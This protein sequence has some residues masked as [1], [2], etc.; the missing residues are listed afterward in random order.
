MKLRDTFIT[1]EP[2][3]S[4]EPRPALGVL[5]E[6]LQGIGDRSL[7]AAQ[8]YL[9]GT[10][11]AVR[12]DWVPAV[13]DNVEF[14]V[15]AVRRVGRVHDVAG[16]E[17][18][19]QVGEGEYNI[20]PVEKLSPFST[21]SRR[22]VAR[23]Q[24]RAALTDSSPMFHETRALIP[25][26]GTDYSMTLEFQ[27]GRRPTMDAVLTY[28]AR[29]YP[30]ARVIDGDDSHPTKLGVVLAFAD[31]AAERQA[32][33]VSGGVGS[34]VS[35]QLSGPKN[36]P[37]D[38]DNA[39]GI[40]K[41]EIEGT[42]K[43]GEDEVAKCALLEAS[44]ACLV[45]IAEANPSYD[46]IETS[47]EETA[48]GVVSHYEVRQAGARCFVKEGRL[49]TV[50]SEGASP[51]VGTIEA[52]DTGVIAYLAH[53]RIEAS[54]YDAGQGPLSI[55][56]N[57]PGANDTGSYVVKADALVEGV[58]SEVDYRREEERWRKDQEQAREEE[59]RR[60][61]RQ[62]RPTVDEQVV[63]APKVKRRREPEQEFE[64]SGVVEVGLQSEEDGEVR[65]TIGGPGLHMAVDESAEKYWA[66]YYGDYGEKLTD[67]VSRHEGR[68][69][70][71]VA[72]THA[73]WREAGQGVPSEADVRLLVRLFTAQVDPSGMPPEGGD[74]PPE[75]GDAPSAPSAPGWFDTFRQ[76][77]R[78]KKDDAERARQEQERLK[79]EDRQWKQDQAHEWSS[80]QTP[81]AL[82]K[83]LLE[84]AGI[85]DK[86]HAYAVKLVAKYVAKLP[87]K[88][89]AQIKV[90]D[91]N[92]MQTLLP[93]AIGL[94]S[95]DERALLAKRY[96]GVQTP[97]H[98]GKGWFRDPARNQP[99]LQR[100]LDVQRKLQPQQP[101]QPQPQQPQPQGQGQGQGQPQGPSQGQP[102]PQGQ[103][104]PQQGQEV[105]L[106]PGQVLVDPA[107]G[108][109][110]QLSGPTR[111]KVA[112]VKPP[113]VLTG[114][115]F[116][117]ESEMTPE[118]PGKRAP[119]PALEKGD[120]FKVGRFGPTWEVVKP[121]GVTGFVQR[122]GHKRK[123]F[124][125]THSRDTGEI[126]VYP[127]NQG[128]GDRTGEPVAYGPLNLVEQA[129]R[130]AREDV[131]AYS[132]RRPPALS[133]LRFR[134][135]DLK[136]VGDYLVLTVVW[137]PEA[138]SAMASASV[139]HNL[140]SFVKQ[141][142]SE[143]ERIDLGFIGRP[144]VD[145]VDFDLGI[146][147]VRVRSS[148]A[149]VAPSVI[150]ER[151]DERYHELA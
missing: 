91:P 52:S 77:R 27:A 80:Q 4:P 111:V 110:Y 104:Q 90:D 137:D 86:V 61:R 125:Y 9:F 145:M 144:V 150:I 105:E 121:E 64:F 97:E 102:S 132:G 129:K 141:R 140:K 83:A 15:G 113:E 107:T 42:G 71:I 12:Q 146:A 75:G 66:D 130:A 48:R 120:R 117:D 13:G 7:R 14:A 28:V 38:R 30:G 65:E 67:P 33:A 78:Q 138:T 3:K 68:V 142:A 16:K 87:P 5:K 44:G 100:G 82:A 24:V 62:H 57:E 88:Q 49:T 40:G 60:R 59:N 122:D 29:R 8:D 127:V 114:F 58:M 39:V 43:I 56:E 147:E 63:E 17:A 1:A 115:D 139:V 96:T 118:E 89:R 31:N 53:E 35:A 2:K 36:P 85:D 51:A 23:D 131:E 34:M 81:D 70:R 103:G 106:T 20:V 10:D 69:R 22:A 74:M 116:F 143:K 128:S 136:R 98:L 41:E 76:K 124:G 94:L 73:G 79:E 54:A 119:D 133:Q 123:W 149:R 148:E 101:Q 95:V 126:A 19:V 151:R 21:T 6:A 50:L 135:E 55:H 92:V 25:L 11:A 134:L 108:Q 18:T 84:A 32:L 47:F 46:F 109:K 72:A 26:G 93:D 45:R 99:S 112:Q 37:S